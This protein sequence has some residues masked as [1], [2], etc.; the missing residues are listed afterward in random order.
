MTFFSFI[1]NQV[2]RQEILKIDIIDYDKIHQ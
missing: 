1:E 2:N